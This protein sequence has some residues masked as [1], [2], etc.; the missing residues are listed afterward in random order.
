[1][2]N[3]KEIKDFVTRVKNGDRVTLLIPD[4]DWEK[5]QLAWLT[6][7]AHIRRNVTLKPVVPAR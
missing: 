4:G 3:N 2:A 7:P 1:M 5:A 6:L